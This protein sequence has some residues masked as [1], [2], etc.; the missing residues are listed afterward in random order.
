VRLTSALASTVLLLGAVTC[1][2]L[3]ICGLGTGRDLGTMYWVSLAFLVLKLLSQVAR[4][5]SMG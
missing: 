3:A 4:A 1:S 2:I 5:G